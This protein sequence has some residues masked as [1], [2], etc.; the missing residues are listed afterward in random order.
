MPLLRLDAFLPSLWTDATERVSNHNLRMVGR[1]RG[2]SFH[3][4]LRAVFR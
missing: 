2:Q 1:V 4:P 3:D